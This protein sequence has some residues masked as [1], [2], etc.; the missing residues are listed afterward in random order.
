M[1]YRHVGT[2]IFFYTAG[3][4]SCAE[5][6]GGGANLVEPF[7]L[8]YPDELGTAADVELLIDIVQVDLDRALA[9][10]Q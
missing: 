1:T 8:R 10:A 2:D 7:F 4:I 6:E 3:Y 9:Y 5:G